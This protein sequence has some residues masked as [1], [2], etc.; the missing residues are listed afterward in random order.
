MDEPV[1]SLDLTEKAKAGF[2][3]AYHALANGPT[4]RILLANYY[5][6]LGDNLPTAAS[7][8]VA[9]LHLD[10]VRGASDLESALNAIPVDRWLSLGLVDGRNVWR[11][12]LR[13]GLASL[14]HIAAVRGAGHLMVAPA[15][16]LLHVPVDLAQEDALNPEVKTW[17]A[18]AVQKLAEVAQLARGLD[19][20]EAVIAAELEASDA[21]KRDPSERCPRAPARRGRTPRR[22]Y[23]R[24]GAPGKFYDSAG[25]YS[26]TG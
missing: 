9:G 20:G 11:T 12:D 16:S 5:G 3:T 23:P 6:P 24:H 13:A 14:H 26:R 22:R 1:L 10:L 18:F 15:C 4:P 2:A 7:L 8:P 21:A 17:L 19:E 25:G